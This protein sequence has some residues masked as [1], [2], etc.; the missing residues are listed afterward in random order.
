MGRWTIK[1]ELR[2][3]REKEKRVC[4]DA[5]L[6]NV[7]LF[8]C[9]VLISR[10]SYLSFRNIM[11]LVANISPELLAIMFIYP[12]PERISHADESKPALAFLLT[13]SLVGQECNASLF[14]GV[15]G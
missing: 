1:A 14:W 2:G 7:L 15:S 10:L 5:T 13:H 9:G 3:E 11:P 8:A 12:N 4:G 6:A